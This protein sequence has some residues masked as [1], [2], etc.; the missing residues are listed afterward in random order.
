MRSRTPRPT[1]PPSPGSLANTDLDV[2]S[3]DDGADPAVDVSGAVGLVSVSA[4]VATRQFRAMIDA[5]L[6][7]DFATARTIISNWTLWSVQ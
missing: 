1:L 4:H 7:G 5:A 6:A 2:Y 3:G